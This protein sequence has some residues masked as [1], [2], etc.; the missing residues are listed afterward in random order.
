MLIRVI[1]IRRIK[2]VCCAVLMG[3]VRNACTT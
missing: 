2:W 3:E 1:E